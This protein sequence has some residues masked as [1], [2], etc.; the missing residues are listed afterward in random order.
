MGSKVGMFQ[1]HSELPQLVSFIEKEWDEQKSQIEMSA[2]N[3]YKKI[4]EM[5]SKW[6]DLKIEDVSLEKEKKQ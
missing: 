5:F 1:P 4:D 2:E 3:A 6:N